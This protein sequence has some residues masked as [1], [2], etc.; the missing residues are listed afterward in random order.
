METESISVGDSQ[1]PPVLVSRIWGV[2][3]RRRGDCSQGEEHFQGDENVL[4]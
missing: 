1:V 3:G 2:G 4:E